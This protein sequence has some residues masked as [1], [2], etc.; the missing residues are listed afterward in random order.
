M[1]NIEVIINNEDPSDDVCSSYTESLITEGNIHMLNFNEE[2]S[3]FH[4]ND[5]FKN[6]RVNS[7]EDSSKH[8]NNYF[9][10]K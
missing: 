3:H 1:E 9:R 2:V 8:H 4:I 5:H 6:L 10:N 7:K